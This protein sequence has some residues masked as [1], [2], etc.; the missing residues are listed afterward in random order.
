MKKIN[1]AVDNFVSISFF[2][3]GKLWKNNVL[4]SCKSESWNINLIISSE[5]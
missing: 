4:I 3:V 1:P 5:R 2:G